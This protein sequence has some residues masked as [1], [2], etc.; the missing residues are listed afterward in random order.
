MDLL[1]FS[2]IFSDSYAAKTLACRCGGNS[3]EKVKTGVNLLNLF[4]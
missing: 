2:S 3:H 1:V 4:N